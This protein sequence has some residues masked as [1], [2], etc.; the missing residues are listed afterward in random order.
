VDEHDLDADPLRQIVMWREDAAGA[1]EP[2]P[3]AMCVATVS[4]EGLPSARMVLL[5]GLDTGLVFYTDYT[6][7]KGADLATTGSAAALFHWRLPTHRQIRVSGPVERTTADESDRYWA[8][9][10]PGS[11]RS[12]VASHQSSVIASRSELER[13]VAEL[14]TADPPRPDR[15][16]GVRIIPETVEFWEEGADRLHDRIRFH[17]HQGE[18]RTERL[19]P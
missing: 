13:R 6:S 15:W 9:R 8:T 12:A 17:R 7:A 10:P 14:G 5:R 16:G 11:R 3:E 18:W 1:G 19:S 4:A 2:S